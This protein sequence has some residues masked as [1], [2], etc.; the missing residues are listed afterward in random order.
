MRRGQL[1]RRRDRAIST[2]FYGN[3]NIHPFKIA[4][5]DHYLGWLAP[6]W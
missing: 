1:A 5:T 6:K 2:S 4:G 3:A